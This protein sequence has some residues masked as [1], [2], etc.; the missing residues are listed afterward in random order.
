MARDG[1]QIDNSLPLWFCDDC[2]YIDQS[3]ATKEC[4]RER[5]FRAQQESENPENSLFVAYAERKNSFLPAAR[6]RMEGSTSFV[7]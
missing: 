6:G 1:Y 7:V 5:S 2:F 3:L 4:L